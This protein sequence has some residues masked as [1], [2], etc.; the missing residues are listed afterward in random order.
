MKAIHEVQW[1]P[2][3]GQK[4]ITSMVEGRSDWC[5]SRQ[6]SWGVPLPVLYYIDTG[7][8]PRTECHLKHARLVRLPCYATTPTSTCFEVSPLCLCCRDTGSATCTYVH[9]TFQ[10]SCFAA[11]ILQQVLE[12]RSGTTYSLCS[13]ALIGCTQAVQLYD[14]DA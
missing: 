4:R 14:Y 9:T 13:L 6:R 11:I 1:L 10:P 5:I 7:T 2:A 8:E 3:S 12:G